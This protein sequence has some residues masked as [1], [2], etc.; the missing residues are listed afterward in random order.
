MRRRLFLAAASSAPSFAWAQPVLPRIG[1]LSGRSPATDGHLLD[2]FRAGLA[3]SGYV[4]GQN[5]VIDPRWAEGRFERLDGLAADLARSKP[6]IMVAVGGTPV[7]LA[8]KTAAP[9]LPIVFTIGTDPVELGLVSNLNRPG[10]NMTG[11]MLSASVLEGKRLD[12]LREMVPEARS[13]VLLANPTSA[14]AAEQTR[15][16]KMAARTLGLALDVVNAATAG[17]IDRGFA[18]LSVARPDALIVSIDGFLIS[19]RTQIIALAA[20]RRMPA[21][22]PSR[23]FPDAG[24]LASY[25]ARWADTYRWVG[26]YAG[27]ILKGARP[28][29]LPVQQPTNYELVVNLKTARTLGLLL[30]PAFMVRADEVIE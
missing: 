8:A 19:R 24:G 28:S 25:A 23:E 13:V 17:E 12:L 10:G 15:D 22:Y 30:P 14:A 27:R 2:A 9:T 5:V 21:I 7:P 26:I 18:A 29:D 3:E 20:E 1:Y 6:T 16:A 4:D 11:A